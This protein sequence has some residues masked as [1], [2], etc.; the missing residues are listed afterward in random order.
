MPLSKATS[1]ALC[2]KLYLDTSIYAIGNDKLSIIFR[3]VLYKI[4][5]WQFAKKLI[6][7][8]YWRILFRR[9]DIIV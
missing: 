3:R 7:K 2:T 6:D 1:Q 5:H 9:L 8:A 4:K